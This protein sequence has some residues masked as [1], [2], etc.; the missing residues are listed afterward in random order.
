M[1]ILFDLY[2]CQFYCGG[3]P[4]Y[5][6]RIWYALQEDIATK[7]LNI[8]LYAMMDCSR[9]YSAYKDLTPEQVTKKGITVVD[10]SK[11]SIS[12]IVHG[13]KI[14]TFFLGLAQFCGKL[15]RKDEKLNCHTI[16]VVHDLCHE[17]YYSMHLRDYLRLNNIPRILARRCVMFFR[18]HLHINYELDTMQNIVAVAKNSHNFQFVTVSEYSKNSLSYYFGISPDKVTVLYSPIRLFDDEECD[19]T[20]IC[21]ELEG[22]QYFLMLSANRENKNPKKLISAFKRYSE[23]VDNNK[24]LVTVG[25]S[26]SEFDKHIALPFLNPKD[27]DHVQ[28]KCFALVYPSFLEGFGYPPV[29]VMKYSKPILASNVTSIPEILG[30]APIYFSPF[31]ESDIFKALSTINDKNYKIYCKKSQER[32]LRINDKQEQDL[33]TMIELLENI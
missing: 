12:D 19:Y 3:A 16:C 5:V 22:K 1:N 14:D 18:K 11:A 10:V 8:T 7:E 6:R 32:F 28:K 13:Y 29:E 27:L 9:N 2:T 24:Y 25:Y 15:L 21:N 31:Y 17:E 4:E 26:K 30:D 20:H 23:L 33:R